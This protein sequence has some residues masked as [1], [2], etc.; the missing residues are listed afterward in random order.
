MSD[1][2]ETAED[3]REQENTGKT[4]YLSRMEKLK[5]LLLENG[6]KKG[7]ELRLS[8]TQHHIFLKGKKNSVKKTW[9]Q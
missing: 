7:G 9:V 5:D 3:D 4:M 8:I 1:K 2:V 6:N